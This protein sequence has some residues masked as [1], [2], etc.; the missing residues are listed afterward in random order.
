M[1][2]VP[3][4]FR[5]EVS[6]LSPVL[7][8][9]SVQVHFS[10]QVPAPG[11]QFREIS[12]RP[13]QNRT[14]APYP[15]HCFL[16]ELTYVWTFADPKPAIRPVN[17][18]RALCLRLSEDLNQR[19]PLRASIM[20]RDSCR[21]FVHPSLSCV[22]S[23]ILT[24]LQPRRASG[25]LAPPPID[26]ALSKRVL[27]APPLLLPL[28][29]GYR[30]P[31]RRLRVHPAFAG[32]TTWRSFYET[33]IPHLPRTIFDGASDALAPAFRHPFSLSPSLIGAQA[34]A[35]GPDWCLHGRSFNLREEEVEE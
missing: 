7:S 22:Q 24:P 25:P 21:R 34:S 12:R 3:T 26:A 14:S 9:F 8:V 32:R 31:H 5:T 19:R 20:T 16:S 29:Q 18:W 6:L 13:R 35:P 10:T 15:G 27:A 4:W 17:Y 33:A 23:P 28:Q 2:N 30:P 11:L 1:F